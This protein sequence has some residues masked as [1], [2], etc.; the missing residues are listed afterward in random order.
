M[1]ILAVLGKYNRTRGLITWRFCEEQDG[2]CFALRND[3]RRYSYASKEEMRSSY[4]FMRDEY[5]FAPCE[6]LVV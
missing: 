2:T 4:R 1:N 5:K 6:L 3:G